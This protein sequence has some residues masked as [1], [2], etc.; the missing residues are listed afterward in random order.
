[1]FTHARLVIAARAYFCGR[2]FR[3][4][5]CNIHVHAQRN[6]ELELPSMYGSSG[7]SYAK[8]QTQEEVSEKKMCLHLMFVRLLV[9]RNGT[10]C[11]P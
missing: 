1:M 2:H 4:E 8:I 11:I 9:D 6:A 3:V 5:V 10:G 7:T